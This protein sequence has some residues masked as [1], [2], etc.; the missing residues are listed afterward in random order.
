[1]FLWPFSEP[2]NSWFWLQLFFFLLLLLGGREFLK[3]YTLKFQKSWFCGFLTNGS[4]AVTLYSLIC[5]SMIFFCCCWHHYRCPPL[6]L[7]V[8]LHPKLLP[9]LH[10][11]IVT[12]HKLCLYAYISL[13]NLP[14]EIKGM[15][16]F[17][18]ILLE[19]C[20][21]FWLSVLLSLIS[22]GSYVF[23]QFF[24]PLF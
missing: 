21:A 8:P 3:L 14:S 23:T 4:L 12:L 17:I 13:A 7:F 19:F 24:C 15:V 16:F 22:Y 5:K 1:M 2:W 18:F 20:W 9:H 6:L 10:H 11:I